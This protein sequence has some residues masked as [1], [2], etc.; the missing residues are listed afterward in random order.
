MLLHMQMHFSARDGLSAHNVRI[1]CVFLIGVCILVYYVYVT[2]LK[3]MYI[4]CNSD[5]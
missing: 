2:C 5:S 1:V 4:D 3:K